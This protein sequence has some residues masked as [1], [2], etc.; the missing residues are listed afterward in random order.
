MMLGIEPRPLDM[1]DLDFTETHSLLF[2]FFFFKSLLFL[3][4][5]DMSGG[6]CAHKYRYLQSTEKGITVLE[7]GVRDCGCWEQH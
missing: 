4:Y 1:L 3:S 6:I 7:A 2:F 5:I